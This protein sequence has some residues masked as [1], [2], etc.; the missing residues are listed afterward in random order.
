MGYPVCLLKRD[1]PDS[2]S[3][4]QKSSHLHDVSHEE[5]HDTRSIYEILVLRSDGCHWEWV[6]EHQ[7]WRKPY[8]CSLAR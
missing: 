5:A 8:E 2:P 1:S 7:K 3:Y 4:W 6:P